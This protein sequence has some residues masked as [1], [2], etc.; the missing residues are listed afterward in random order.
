MAYCPNCGEESNDSSKFCKK[1]GTSLIVQET[2]AETKTTVQ[3]APAPKITE[4]RP[5]TPVGQTISG[6]HVS[7]KFVKWPSNLI[8]ISYIERVSTS[9]PK[10]PFPKLSLLLLLIGIALL[11]SMPPLG[12]VV[13]IAAVA[14]IFFWAYKNATAPK[15]ITFYL[16]SGGVTSIFLSDHN[17]ADGIASSIRRAIDGED[18][19]YHVDVKSV[20]TRDLMSRVGLF[21]N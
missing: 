9:I 12:A 1:C 18:V 10:T 6:I 20:Q 17:V 2:V 16:N 11:F 13:A 19:E 5:A 3:E 21:G 15:G 7:S 14:W 8:N 4:A